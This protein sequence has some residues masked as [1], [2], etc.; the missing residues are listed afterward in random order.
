M[1]KFWSR[2]LILTLCLCLCG[3]DEK[4][5]EDQTLNT[6]LPTQT[7]LPSQ[8][9]TSEPTRPTET[10][11]TEPAGSQPTEP[12][13]TEPQPTEPAETQPQPTEPEQTQPEQ[14]EP[15]PTQPDSG[16]A[17]QPAVPQPGETTTLTL[18]NSGAVRVTYSVNV[19]SVRYITSAAQL[20]DYPELAGYDDAYFETGALILVMESVSSSSVRVSIGSVTLNDTTALVTLTHEGTGDVSVPAMATWLVWAEVEKDLHYSWE[21]ANPALDSNIQN[22]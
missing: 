16:S 17:L 6:T 15:E 18:G 3:C 9:P 22:S 5:P 20:P 10:D 14:T 19:S 13:Q 11:A 4:E 12:A 2:L 8:T 7:Q 1:S 21:V